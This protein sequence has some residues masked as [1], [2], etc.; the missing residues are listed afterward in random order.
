VL[1][2]SLLTAIRRLPMTSDDSGPNS[3]LGDMAA[4]A[5]LWQE[6]RPKLLGM[7]QRRIS[8]SLSSRFDPEDVLSE[9][10]LEARRKW[11]RFKA[12]GS[13]TPYAWLYRVTLDTLIEVWRRQNRACRS[14]EREMTWPER[15]SV[16][17]GLGLVSAV[18][19]PGHA[20]DARELQEQMQQA[21]DRLRPV[22]REILLMRH[23]DELTFREAA[24]VLGI[25]ETAANVR[26]VRALRR[27]KQLWHELHGS[28]GQEA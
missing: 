2:M 21:L 12:S 11:P 26:Y 27:L 4:L 23:Y 14:P 6:H 25:K 5:A 28:G 8:P 1:G 18:E 13:L 24:S 19:S 15:S 10:F 7:I 3:S 9:A 22:D 17:L 16:Q 20:A